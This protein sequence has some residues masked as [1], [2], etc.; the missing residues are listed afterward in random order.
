ME[1]IL[2]LKPIFKE[3]IWGGNQLKSLYSY[4]VEGSIGEC[5]AIS[6]L[7]EASNIILNGTYKGKT[8]KEVYDQHKHLFNNEKSNIYPIMTKIIDAKEDLSIQVHA[9]DLNI[10]KTECWYILEAKPQSS[11]VYGHKAQDKTALIDFVNQGKWDELLVTQPVE[12]GDFI[13]VPAGTI[14]AIGKGIVLL[15][16]QQPSDVTYRLYDYDRLDQNHHKRQLH[17][18][19][20]MEVTNVPFIKPKIKTSNIILD[21]ITVTRFIENEYFVVEKWDIDSKASVFSNHFKNI[22]VIEGLGTINAF[23]IQKGDHFII[24]SLKQ[25]L[26]IEGKM[27]MI[28]SYQ[29]T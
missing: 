11:I 20:A 14:H 4:D 15:E 22:S 29:L 24:T 25:V 6:G 27:T 28:V 3:R 19:K 7:T 12:K 23:K 8:L 26:T 16:T 17:I 9:K 1:K 21:G 5:W 13:Y 10:S 18:K 2:F